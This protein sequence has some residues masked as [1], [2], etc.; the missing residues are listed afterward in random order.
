MIRIDGTLQAVWFMNV[1]GHSNWMAALNTASGAKVLFTWRVLY[2]MP[3][4]APFDDDDRASWHR[5][6]MTSK[7]IPECV[8]T[9]RSIARTMTQHAT[10]KLYEVV[11]GDQSAADFLAD[12]RCQPWMA[13]TF[14]KGELP[15]GVDGIA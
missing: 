1:N 11:R 12:I 2:F 14:A 10:G 4:S 3:G 15:P 8:D 7:S 9:V 13:K 5:A 6:R